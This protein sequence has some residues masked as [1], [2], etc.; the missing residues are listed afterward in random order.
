MQLYPLLRSTVPTL[1]GGEHKL[2][3]LILLSARICIILRL[4]DA[5]MVANHTVTSR[6]EELTLE[7]VVYPWGRIKLKAVTSSDLNHWK[8][9]MLSV[10]PLYGA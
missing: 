9:S 7:D 4:L 1:G 5:A 2:S 8:L 3:I 6:V 10:K